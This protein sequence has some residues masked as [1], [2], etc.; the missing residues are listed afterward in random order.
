MQFFIITID[1]QNLSEFLS[2][3]KM[4]WPKNK[5]F[6]ILPS[7]AFMRHNSYR[8][9]PTGV[10]SPPNQSTNA[11]NHLNT[12]QNVNLLMS[13]KLCD[14][15]AQDVKIQ[16]SSYF[17]PEFCLAITTPLI[18]AQCISTLTTYILVNLYV[19]YLAPVTCWRSR[20]NFLF[21]ENLR[22]RGSQA[23][24]VTGGRYTTNKFT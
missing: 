20:G 3:K 22:F 17:A 7:D 10:L 15:I 1:C 2:F 8:M 14:M 6:P 12:V 13:H 16:K 24:Q 18:P 21:F 9:N 19:V 23:P 5:D 4:L 11:A